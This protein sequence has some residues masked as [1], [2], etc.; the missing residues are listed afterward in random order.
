MSAWRR[1][2]LLAIPECKQLISASESPMALW[3][4]LHFEFEKAFQADD[5]PRIRRF[6]EYAKWCWDARDGATVNAVA[7]AFARRDVASAA[8]AQDS[9]H[10]RIAESFG[11]YPWVGGI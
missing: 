2:A 6:I 7:C 10:C 1:Q 8:A 5:L 9:K 4:E 11:C 3:I